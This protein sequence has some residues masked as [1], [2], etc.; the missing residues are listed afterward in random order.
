MQ[1]RSACRVGS[2][3]HQVCIR[4]RQI[5][6]FLPLTIFFG[7]PCNGR[8]GQGNRGRGRRRGRPPV[9]AVGPE[10]EHRVVPSTFMSDFFR[11]MLTVATIVAVITCCH[12]TAQILPCVR[13]RGTKSVNC[14][15]HVTGL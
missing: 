11:E 9:N 1:R 6:R 13:S 12:G 14:T 15:T 5:V 7:P 2:E 8:R 4:N 10:D 3:K